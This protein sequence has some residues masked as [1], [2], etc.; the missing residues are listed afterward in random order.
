MVTST[1]IIV[2]IVS[3]LSIGLILCEVDSEEEIVIQP[4]I[5]KG[6]GYSISTMINNAL[7][8]NIEY[9]SS[10]STILQKTDKEKSQFI[11]DFQK[12]MAINNTLNN[13]SSI[14]FNNLSLYSDKN[15]SISFYYP[16]S[17]NI[18]NKY[19]KDSLVTFQLPL[20]NNDSKFKP[21]VGIYIHSLENIPRIQMIDPD[22]LKLIYFETV[23]ESIK[24]QNNTINHNVSISGSR[25]NSLND[26]LYTGRLNNS[27]LD[28]PFWGVIYNNNNN[29]YVKALE[30]FTI[31][32]RKV[33][34]I[35]YLA[36]DNDFY[37]LYP[38]VIK[39]IRSFTIF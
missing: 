24:K 34:V 33:H 25:D 23:V 21:R 15:N 3:M 27:L 16:T 12:G 4:S 26:F 30:I 19:N 20:Q 6:N 35:L 7:L 14:Q 18:I 5:S 13:S 8:G 28:S 17:W 39:L 31:K 10:N 1:L 22:I 11:K 36:S 32:D 38:D 2:F 29:N 37:N 9:I